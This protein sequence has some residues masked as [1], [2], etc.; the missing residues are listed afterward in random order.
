MSYLFPRNMSSLSPQEQ[1]EGPEFSPQEEGLGFFFRTKNQ[2]FGIILPIASKLKRTCLE[3]TNAF[4]IPLK[5]KPQLP[6]PLVGFGEKY[7]Q[8]VAEKNG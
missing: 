7:G 8:P 2:K 5:F 6:R 1:R 4:A 3:E